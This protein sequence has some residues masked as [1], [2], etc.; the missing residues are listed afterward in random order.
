MRNP[1]NAQYLTLYH[2]RTKGENPAGKMARALDRSERTV[3]RCTNI[4]ADLY[5]FAMTIEAKPREV[6]LGRWLN[7]TLAQAEPPEGVELRIDNRLEGLDLR[8]R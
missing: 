6:D 5:D 7:Q 4:L 1:L 8:H 2:P 3:Q